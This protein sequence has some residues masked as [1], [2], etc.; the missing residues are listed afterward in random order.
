[1][2]KVAKWLK[3]QFGGDY[4]RAFEHYHR[5]KKT[6]GINKT[7]LLQLLRDAGVGNALMG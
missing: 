7:E 4:R 1:V 2:D 6:G 3:E 5:D